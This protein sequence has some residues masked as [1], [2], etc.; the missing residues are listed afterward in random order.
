[1]GFDNDFHLIMADYDIC[2]L[3]TVLLVDIFYTGLFSYDHLP[4]IR[5]FH[6]LVICPPAV[7]RVPAETIF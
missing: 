6:R 4:A 5:I 1:M 7:V 3:Y 2:I